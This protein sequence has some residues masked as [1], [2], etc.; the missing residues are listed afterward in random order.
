MLEF[1]VEFVTVLKYDIELIVI[2]AIKVILLPL[3]VETF[4]I[5]LFPFL[6]LPCLRLKGG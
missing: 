4:D 5:A 3:T 6:D 1:T 2:L